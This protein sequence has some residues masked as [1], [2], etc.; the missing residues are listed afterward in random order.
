MRFLL[1][2]V[3]VLTLFGCPKSTIGD[4]LFDIN[5]P[6]LEFTVPAGQSSFRTF[7]VARPEFATGFNQ[8]LADNGVDVDDIDLVGGVRARITSI[9][10]EDF[11]EI[12]RIELRVCPAS[13]SDCT[14]I[15]LMFSISDLGG[16][17][18]QVVNLN[19]GEKNFRSLFLTEENVRME[20]VF[21][22]LEVTTRNIDARL[23]WTIGAIGGL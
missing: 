18:Q 17:R 16:R 13:E 19:P 9:S 23:E 20:L 8:A 1:F 10:G 5:Y 3:L 6:V 4:R 7:V 15:D 21:F 14:F 2:S 22:P 12:E 11:R